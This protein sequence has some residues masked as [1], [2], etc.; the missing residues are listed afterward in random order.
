[1]SAAYS[2]GDIGHILGLCNERLMYDR[3]SGRLTWKTSAG[4][5]VKG[6][7]AGS[8]STWGYLRIP[9]NKTAYSAHRLIWLMEYG[10]WPSGQIDHVD[11]NKLN[12]SISNLRDVS[13][14]ANQLAKTKPPRNNTSG[15]VGVT[16]HRGRYQAVL[17][18]NDKQQ[19]LGAFATAEEAG[20][21][22]RSA[23]EKALQA[24][25]GITPAQ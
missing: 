14:S 18:V 13:A 22:Y 15:Y 11:G 16:R 20:A 9:L 10:R 4:G 5:V 8:V 7:D 23:K 12:N 2:S 25:L 17:K 19:F 6:S 3:G 24:A 21:A 1:M